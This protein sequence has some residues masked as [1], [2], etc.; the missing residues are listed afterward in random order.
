[1]A[2]N[3][4]FLKPDEGK[5]LALAVIGTLDQ[6]KESMKKPLMNWTPET[7]KQLKE[8][9]DAGTS[10]SIKLQRLGFNMS[11]LPPFMDGDENEFLTKQS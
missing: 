5:F 1:M 9:V 8:M 2:T 7:R 10:L 4:L 3:N 6:L 11:D